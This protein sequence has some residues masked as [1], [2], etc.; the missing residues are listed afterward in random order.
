MLGIAILFLIVMGANWQIQ[1]HEQII[2]KQRIIV[3]A[4]SVGL[5]LL[6]ELFFFFRDQWTIPMLLRMASNSIKSWIFT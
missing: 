5:F 6:A 2:M 3:L 4:I 1:H